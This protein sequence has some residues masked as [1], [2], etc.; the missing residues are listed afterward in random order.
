MVVTTHGEFCPAAVQLQECL[1]EGYR[2]R[3]RFEG[4][5]DDGEKED[6]LMTAFCCE[7]RASLLVATAK[8][9]AEMLAVAGRPFMKGGAKCS[10]ADAVAR[11]AVARVVSASPAP[12]LALSHE[13][14]DR[15]HRPIHRFTH[16]T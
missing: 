9:T 14:P 10:R 6:D 15:Q 2:A 13:A 7:L 16:R 11:P 5:R 3:L 1:V 8:G 12:G 4:E